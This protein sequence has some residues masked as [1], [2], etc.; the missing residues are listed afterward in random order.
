MPTLHELLRLGLPEEVEVVAGGAYL[1]REVHWVVRVRA[2][3]PALPPLTGGELVLVSIET[4]Q[5]LDG[6]PSL[7][8]VIGQLAELGV[9]AT[10]VI[11]P[12]DREAELAA[13]H[14]RLPLISGSLTDSD[15]KPSSSN[16]SAGW[17]SA[18][19]KCSGAWRCF[20]TNSLASPWPAA[21]LPCSTAPCTSRTRRP[22]YTDSTG[23]CACGAI[24]WLPRPVRKWLTQCSSPVAQKPSAGRASSAESIQAQNRGSRGCKFRT[25]SWCAWWPAL[26]M[27][28]AP[29]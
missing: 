21:S 17:S 4:L 24:Q 6:R 27:T 22:C 2:H 29:V 10:A 8:R 28:R 16:F 1:D 26:W 9:P 7:A 5:A 19:W 13:M 15:P 14:A 20:T 3:A 25:C 18:S 23:R 12:V 11:G